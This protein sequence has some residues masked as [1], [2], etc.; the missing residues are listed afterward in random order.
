[1]DAVCIVSFTAFA[2][3]SLTVL[4]TIACGVDGSAFGFG[5]KLERHHQKE[6][7]S[8]IKL[9]MPNIQYRRLFF[10]ITHYFLE[11][12]L[13]QPGKLY[14]YYQPSILPF[15]QPLSLCV[16]NTMQRVPAQIKF[17]DWR[18]I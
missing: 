17:F 18:D 6:T 16:P 14:G 5:F 8:T 3:A 2:L 9:T 7:A 13:E 11:H 10:F 1:M 4:L 15:V 12:V